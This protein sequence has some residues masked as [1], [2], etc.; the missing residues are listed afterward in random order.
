VDEGGGRENRGEEQRASQTCRG[1]PRLPGTAVRARVVRGGKEGAGG[2]ADCG[3]GVDATPA[4]LYQHSGSTSLQ[5]SIAH[6]V[7]DRGMMD[8]CLSPDDR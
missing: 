6:A 2:C 3:R 7:R 4:A 8:K 5:P 1:G